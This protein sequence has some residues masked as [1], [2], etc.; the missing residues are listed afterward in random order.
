MLLCRRRTERCF[1]SFFCA[2]LLSRS[3]PGVSQEKTDDFPSACTQRTEKEATLGSNTVTRSRRRKK[4]R[5]RRNGLLFFAA[6]S[7]ECEKKKK[8]KPF[9]FLSQPFFFSS[10]SRFRLSLVFISLPL[11]PLFSPKPLLAFFAFFH[12]LQDTGFIYFSGTF[13]AQK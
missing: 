11:S 12:F 1:F 4:S 8:N 9:F 2:S 7:C 13:A 3:A 5:N 6:E 10:L